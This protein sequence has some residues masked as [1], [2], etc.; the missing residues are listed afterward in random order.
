MKVPEWLKSLTLQ[1]ELLLYFPY[2]GNSVY[3]EFAGYLEDWQP[4]IR[5]QYIWKGAI[6]TDHL[7][8]DNYKNEPDSYDNWIA[9]EM[10]KK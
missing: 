4:G 1:Q 8:Y 10:G 5:V 3:A 2:T 7:Q 6:K 9:Y